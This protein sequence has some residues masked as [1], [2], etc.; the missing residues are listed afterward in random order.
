VAAEVL[1]KASRSAGE[2]RYVTGLSSIQGPLICEE[3][4]IG[5]LT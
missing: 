1:A 4:A 5:D 2:A 3:R